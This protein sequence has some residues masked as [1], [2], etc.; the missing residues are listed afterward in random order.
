MVEDAERFSVRKTVDTGNILAGYVNKGLVG[1]FMDLPFVL[2]NVV[3]EALGSDLRSPLPSQNLLGF[4]TGV[5]FDPERASTDKALKKSL[6][7]LGVGL[8]FGVGSVSYTHLTL[9]TKA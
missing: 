5:F 6:R 7:P 1:N 2:G 9:P 3:S 8:E 4:D